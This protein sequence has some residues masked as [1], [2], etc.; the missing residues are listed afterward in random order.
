METYI[1]SGSYARKPN[2]PYTPG[3]DVSG[4][5]EAVGDGVYLLQVPWFYLSTCYSSCTLTTSL[6]VCFAWTAIFFTGRGQ[7][8]HHRHSDRWIR[9]VYCGLRGHCSQ[10]S[11]LPRL[12]TGCSYGSPIFHCIQSFSSQVRFCSLCCRAWDVWN[13]RNVL[14]HFKMYFFSRAH[15]KAGETVLIHGASGGVGCA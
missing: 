1:R 10:A 7:S 11:W 2:L 3:S 9:W 13:Y 15:A 12:Q 4:V 14:M 6:H 5:V 8:L